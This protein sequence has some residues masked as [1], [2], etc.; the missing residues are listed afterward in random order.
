MGGGALWDWWGGLC[1]AP[2]ALWGFSGRLGGYVGGVEAAAA[3]FTSLYSG[4]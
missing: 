4:I 2:G 1:G 3:G